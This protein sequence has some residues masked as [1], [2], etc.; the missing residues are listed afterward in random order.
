MSN[1]DHWNEVYSKKAEAELSWHQDDPSV[2][3]DLMKTAGLT[4]RSSVI[5]I[6]AGTSRLMDRLLDLGLSDLSAC[7]MKI[8]AFVRN[9]SHRSAF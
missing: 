1:I 3:L 9:K 6:G 8:P 2:A 7:L 5:D 4:E